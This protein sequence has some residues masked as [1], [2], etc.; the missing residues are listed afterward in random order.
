MRNCMYSSNKQGAASTTIGLALPHTG[1]GGK[2]SVAP[3]DVSHSYELFL[4]QSPANED[5]SLFKMMPF[6]PGN[7]E[8]TVATD[9]LGEGAGSLFVPRPAEH[10]TGAGMGM[11]ALLTVPVC[12]LHVEANS[13]G[14]IF[15]E[16]L[17]C[18]S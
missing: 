3:T 9:G 13:L 1:C 2:V 5:P 6:T 11:G 10:E 12:V 15:T 8:G 16:Q 4:E 17:S 14:V 7:L 18:V